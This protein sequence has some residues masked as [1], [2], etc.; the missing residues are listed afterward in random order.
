MMLINLNTYEFICV[1]I[2]STMLGNLFSA[3]CDSFV[4]LLSTKK[5]RKE[6]TK[7]ESDS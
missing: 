4:E 2:L 7:N 3:I 6:K 5:Q 1:I